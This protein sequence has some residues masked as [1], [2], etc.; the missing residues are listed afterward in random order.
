MRHFAS[1]YFLNL[2]VILLYI[3]WN[4]VARNKAQ[5]AL[6]PETKFHIQKCGTCRDIL[7][8]RSR[9]ICYFTMVQ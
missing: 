4:F 8:K 2:T 3:H 1:V 7:E 5:L 6:F 9:G